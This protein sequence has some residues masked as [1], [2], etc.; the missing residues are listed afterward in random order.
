MV[1]HLRKTGV[2][3]ISFLMLFTLTASSIAQETAPAAQLQEQN[4]LVIYYSRSGT[5]KMAAESLKNSLGCEEEAIISKVD[6]SGFSG[7]ITGVIDQLMDR[8][9][10]Q[11]PFGK[12]LQPYNPIYIAAPVWIGNIASPARTVIKGADLKGKDV[13]LFLTYNGKLSPEKETAIASLVSA[14]GCRVKIFK[15]VTKGKTP[16]DIDREIK[17]IV[18]GAGI[19]KKAEHHT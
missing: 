18:A 15:I 6:R 5:T 1:V 13:F 4:P 16:A 11:A 12:S 10:D 19:H 7:I 9:D 14:R 3:F 2:L 17:S 8:D